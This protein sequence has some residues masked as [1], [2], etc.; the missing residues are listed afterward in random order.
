[1]E[2][3]LPEAGVQGEWCSTGPSERLASAPVVGATADS[4][5]RRAALQPFL[6]SL[7]ED[8]GPTQVSVPSSEQ[9]LLVNLRMEGGQG[10]WP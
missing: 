3:V 8:H 9:E 4:C 6:P 2:A 10:D 1:M 7:S 5:L